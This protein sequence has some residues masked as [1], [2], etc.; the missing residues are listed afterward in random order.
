MFTQV[1]GRAG[2]C[3]KGPTWATPGE[4]H[5]ELPTFQLHLPPPPPHPVLVASGLRA[6]GHMLRVTCSGSTRTNY[7]GFN[8]KIIFEEIYLQKLWWEQQIKLSVQDHFWRILT[9][10]DKTM[11]NQQKLFSETVFIWIN[12]SANSAGRPIIFN[13]IKKI[14]VPNSWQSYVIY[15]YL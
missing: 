5:S 6:Q 11:Q 10:K 2:S 12:S 8:P 7:K 4:P 1:P 14:S 13:F 9:I 3:W 15:S